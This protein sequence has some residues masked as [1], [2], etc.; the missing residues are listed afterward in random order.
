M[1][2]ANTTETAFANA[3]FM[4]VEMRKNGQKMADVIKATG[5]NHTQ[6]EIAF[7]KATLPASAF[8][9]F[10]PAK[11]VELR[12]AGIAWGVIGVMLNVPESRVRKAYANATGNLSEG[13]RNG[14]GGRFLNAD[15]VLYADVL[16]KT[17]TTIPVEYGRNGARKAAVECRM[18]KLEIAELRMLAADYGVSGKGTKAQIINRIKKAMA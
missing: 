10:S 17:G 4:A 9:E 16:A 2:I 5:L 11:V 18:V 14:K 13:Q 6:V 3:T 12:E 15:G 8:A 7:L 1:D